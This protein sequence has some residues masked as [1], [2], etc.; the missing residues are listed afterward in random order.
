MARTRAMHQRA[1]TMRGQ[2]KLSRVYL[3]YIS[4]ASRVH[5]ECISTLSGGDL[6]DL[7]RQLERFHMDHDRLHRLQLE[8][9]KVSISPAEIA[10][11]VPELARVIRRTTAT[12]DLAARDLVARDPPPCAPVVPP[13]HN[14]PPPRRGACGACGATAGREQ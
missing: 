7:R 12:H 1:G 6:R 5:R 9:G 2:G 4:S 14:V 8:R 11:A 10:A 13:R 3:E